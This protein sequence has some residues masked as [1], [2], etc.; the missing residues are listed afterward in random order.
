MG[1]ERLRLILLIALFGVTTA[2]VH[3]AGN[4]RAEQKRQPDWRA[5]PYEFSGWTGVDGQFDP[6]YGT[7]PADT[8]VLRVY[9]RQNETPVI[10]YVG[11]YSDLTTIM[12]VHSPELCYPAQGW[13]VLSSRKFVAGLYRGSQISA[14]EIIVA[15]SDE[16]RLVTWWYNAGAHPFENRIHYVYAFLALATVTAR[17]DGSMVRIETPIEVT[18]ESAAQARTQM[19]R[20]SFLPILDRA[21]PQ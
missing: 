20:T 8:S 6:I 17:T 4:Y 16:R 2:G 10:A 12:D 14:Q 1:N 19:F 15:K 18:G 13:T 21:L 5:V 3:A 9:S 7:D 11:F